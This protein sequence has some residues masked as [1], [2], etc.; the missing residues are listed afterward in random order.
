[1][2]GHNSSIEEEFKAKVKVLN[3]YEKNT[4]YLMLSFTLASSH[5]EW[6]DPDWLWWGGSFDIVAVSSLSKT[7]FLQFGF[8]WRKVLFQLHREFCD[9]LAWNLKTVS[10]RICSSGGD[11]LSF[12]VS[13]LSL[14]SGEIV[15]VLTAGADCHSTEEFTKCLLGYSFPL[16]S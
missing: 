12:C 3:I 10:N 6:D 2:Y 5:R 16:C 8:K 15:T 13:H 14:I 1:M 7:L 4:H 9:P 11:C